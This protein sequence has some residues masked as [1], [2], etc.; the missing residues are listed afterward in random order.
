MNN[1]NEF[2]YNNYYVGVSHQFELCIEIIP[3]CMRHV[4][5]YLFL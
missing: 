2:N 1:P 5:L 3:A 4:V